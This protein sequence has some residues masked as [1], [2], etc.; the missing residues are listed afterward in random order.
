MK[1]PKRRV[2]KAHWQAPEESPDKRRATDKRQRE[3]GDAASIS[4]GNLFSMGMVR[5]EE[6]A[7][8]QGC[9]R[10]WAS[11]VRD[12]DGK[13]PLDVVA[14][15]PWLTAGECPLGAD[16][17]GCGGLQGWELQACHPKAEY[18]V[19]EWGMGVDI[20]YGGPQ[21][22][23]V[24]CENNPSF[25]QWPA[26]SAKVVAKEVD[27]GRWVGPFMVPPVPGFRQTPLAMVEERDKYRHITN[28]K[29]GARVNEYIP[30][31]D[32]P[33]YLSADAR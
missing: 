15:A 29:M 8:A 22:E 19:D 28:A 18:L 2:R 5:K 20:R 11:C 17:S 23:T 31:P 14:I 4:G 12:G 1:E 16:R 9:E 32:E 6:Q 26:E 25:W 13:A 21:D 10:P 27:A 7:V 33:V 3:M 24:T 30:D